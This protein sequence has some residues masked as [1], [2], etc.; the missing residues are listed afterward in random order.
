MTTYLP[1]EIQDGLDAARARDLA[2]KSRYRVSM[3]EQ[4]YKILKLT[5]GGFSVDAEAAPHLRGLVDIFDG[6]RQLY[7]CLIVASSEENG[8]MM[9]EYKRNTVA[10]DK[11]PL[12]FYR[13]PN[14]PIA[15]LGD[16][17]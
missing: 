6:A 10:A 9:Y 4:T 8:Q 5:E 15:L 12:D 11:A 1:K 16:E 3:N 14:A 13:E 2:R 7:Q 17:R